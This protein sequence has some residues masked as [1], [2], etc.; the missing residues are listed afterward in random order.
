MKALLDTNF[1]M[2]PGE[3][4]GDVLSNLL[5]LGYTEV[6]APD[7]VIGELEKLSVGKGKKSRNAR[8]GLEFIRKGEVIVLKAEERNTDDEIFRLAKTKE[9]IACTQDRELINRIKRAG[10]R[11]ITLRQGKYLVESGKDI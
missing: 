5:D 10:L 11:F 1:L 7:L 6:V 2:L 3:F 8:I 9:Y 4:G